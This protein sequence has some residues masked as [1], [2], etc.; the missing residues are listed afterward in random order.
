MKKLPTLLKSPWFWV[1]VCL[2]II[3]V[4]VASMVSGVWFWDWP[5]TVWNWLRDEGAIQE[6]NSTTLRNFGFVIAGVFALGIAV[7]RSVIADK[8]TKV[9]E[10]QADVARL[11]LLNERYQR[12]AE[13]LGN[14]ALA[15]RVGGI[16]ALT[17]VAAE[18]PVEYYIRVIALLCAFAR[19]PTNGNSTSDPLVS[20]KLVS[21][22]WIPVLRDDLQEIT[23]VIR[24]RGKT[25]LDLE[26]EEKYVLNLD[27]AVLQG[28]DFRGADLRKAH[29]MGANLSKADFAGCKLE[30][31]YFEGANVTGAIFRTV[32]L[33]DGVPTYDDPPTGL[34]QK[35]VD[36]TCRDFYGSPP[37]I[38]DLYDPQTMNPI[39]WNGT[40][41]PPPL[42]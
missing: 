20:E 34:T 12:G 30:D 32:R 28:A 7:W 5:C 9:S 27:H 14:N 15:V 4:I 22:M 8:Q 1:V 31:T 13:M 39:D 36:S 42:P 29:F 23:K 24:S 16:H 3:L 6:S 40:T 18:R 17:F 11:S 10:Q 35:Q 2:A 19:N 26:N 41:L 33:K 21:G 25:E 38:V 37:R